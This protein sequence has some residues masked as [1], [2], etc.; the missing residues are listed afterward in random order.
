MQPLDLSR[1][2]PSSASPP[3]LAL[4]ATAV[5]E[6][7]APSA[8]SPLRS[9]EAAASAG[10]ASPAA[11]LGPL[12]LSSSS[13]DTPPSSSGGGPA[14]K[15]FLTKYLHKDRG[16][17]SLGRRSRPSL[18]LSLF[19]SFERHLI[20]RFPESFLPAMATDRRYLRP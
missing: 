10:E 14:R 12:N 13:P 7:V 6:P 3:P 8:A 20:A 11:A 5:V 4:A 9:A 1:P 17:S 18:S 16:E 2:R 15:R 19:P